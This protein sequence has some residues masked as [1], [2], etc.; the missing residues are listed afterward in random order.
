MKK[1]AGI[2]VGAI[3]ISIVLAGCATST[4]TET[5]TTSNQAANTTAAK[6]PQGNTT[7]TGDTKPAESLIH[8]AFDSS[9]I[10]STN[11]RIVEAHARYIANHP[12]VKIR[13]EGHTDERGTRPYNMGLGERRAQAVSRALRAITANAKKMD[14]VSYGEEKP[15]ASAHDE[16]TWAQNRRVQIIYQ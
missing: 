10:D 4:N 6:D 2:L 9:T 1:A 3:G 7:P 5:P 11:A 14:L 16:K 8:F 15:V 12:N 13:L